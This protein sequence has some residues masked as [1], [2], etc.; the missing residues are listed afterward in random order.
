MS[1]ECSHLVRRCLNGD[2][3]AWEELVNEYRSLV[4]SIC[5]LSAISDQDADDLAQEAFI[6][7]WMNLSNYDPER[8]ALRSWI[9]SI[10]RNLRVDRFRR[11][12]YE[13]VTDSMDDGWENS[14]SVTLALRIVDSRQSPHDSAFSNEASAIVHQAVNGISPI[15]RDV[16]TLHLTQGLDSREIARQLRIPEGTVKS[17]V[18]RGLAQLTSLLNP[19]RAALGIA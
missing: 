16:V 12:G 1:T 4:Y 8:G 7:I 14:G 5:H 19:Q 9:A 13:R 6:K 2:A 11:H 18:H 15:M 3:A 10:T 17:R